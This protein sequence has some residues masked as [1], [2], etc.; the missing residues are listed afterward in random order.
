MPRLA[1][2]F[3]LNLVAGSPR[4]DSALGHGRGVMLNDFPAISVPAIDIGEACSDHRAVGE[5]ESIHAGVDGE[6]TEDADIGLIN[7]SRRPL[8]EKLD[9]VVLNF[10]VVVA[11]PI[12]DGRQQDGIRGIEGGHLFRVASLQC[13][14]PSFEEC[15]D[16]KFAHVRGSLARAWTPV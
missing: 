7:L 8:G 1:G 12:G 13:G 10:L 4:T 5:S 3:N 11:D 14:I 6:I 2:N 15:S 16:V 9:E